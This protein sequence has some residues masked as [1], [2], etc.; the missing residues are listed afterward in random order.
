MGK[1]AAVNAATQQVQQGD[2]NDPV[3]QAMLQYTQRMAN[4]Y[5]QMLQPK[6]SGRA[7]NITAQQDSSAA[8]MAIAMGLL[9]PAVQ[10]A[11]SAAGNAV[12]G[13]NLR[14][15]GLA[16]HNYHDL[17]RQFPTDITDEQG[18]KL[19]SWRVRLLPFFEAGPLYEQFRQNEPWDSK[20]N[21]QLLAQMP[22]ALKNPLVPDPTATNYLATRGAGT[23]WED[24][25]AK[26]TF[27]EILDG[28]SNTIMV[29]EANADKAVPW[30]K[31]ADLDVD[32]SNPQAGLGALRP[33]GGFQALFGDGSV[34]PIGKEVS[35]EILRAMFTRAGG[36]VIPR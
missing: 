13:N 28:T 1:E 15:I 4:H 10:S 19:L 2:P 25:K 17:H 5:V 34:Q 18:N 27:A 29:V 14:Q 16:I 30:T 33:A 32:P 8:T 12:S 3:Q 21:M 6:R 22:E 24:G 23:F 9:L 26:L 36:E 20:H 35:A 11:R 7:V 31:P